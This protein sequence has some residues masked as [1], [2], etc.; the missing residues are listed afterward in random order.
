MTAG[1]AAAM[2]ALPSLRD[3][4]AVVVGDLML[5]RYWHGDAARISPEAPVPVVTVSGVEDRP[6]VK[7]PAKIAAFLAA[8]RAAGAPNPAETR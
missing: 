2:P 7:N 8:V 4:H 6:G 5:D 1:E 3:V